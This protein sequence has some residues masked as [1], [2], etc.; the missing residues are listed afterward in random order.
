MF[1]KATTAK[2]NDFEGQL[3]YIN[4]DRISYVNEFKGKLNVVLE[5]STGK[6]GFLFDGRERSRIE[7]LIFNASFEN[8]ELPKAKS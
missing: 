4:F 5:G 8:S 6:V 3:V 1:I 2:E 7:T